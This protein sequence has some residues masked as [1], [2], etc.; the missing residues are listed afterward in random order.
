LILILF[1]EDEEEGDMK[2]VS[3]KR[4]KKRIK[5][6]SDTNRKKHDSRDQ[7]NRNEKGFLSILSA[8]GSIETRS[9]KGYLLSQQMFSSP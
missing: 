5:E 4:E 3:C 6:T 2:E 7:Q 1:Q 9:C 8:V